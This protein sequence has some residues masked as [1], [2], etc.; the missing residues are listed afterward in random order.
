MKK[1]IIAL[2]LAA[3]LLSA[4]SGPQTHK[5][6][7]DYHVCALVWPSCHDDSLGRVNWE[8]GIGEWE[9]IKKGDPRFEGHY[10]PKLPLW[11]YEMDNDP[12][13]IEKWI[14]TALGHGV[15]TFIYDW[16]WFEHYPFLESALNDGFLKAPSNE[17]MEFFIMWANHDVR[18]CFW[19]YHKWGDDNS[20]LWEGAIDPADFP[21]IV[22]RIINQYF[23]RPN[24]TKIDGCPVFGLFSTDNFFKSFPSR[25]EAVAAMDYMR[26]EVK[27]AGF[28]GM[29]L[30]MFDPFGFDFT[31]HNKDYINS[32]MILKPDSWS[33]YGMGG[34]DCDYLKHGENANMIREEWDA[35]LDIPLF[36]TVS[37]GWDS[38]PR[39]PQN[40]PAE[41]TRFNQTPTVFKS[42]LLDAKNFAD[43]HPDRPKFVILNAWNEWVEGTYLLPDKLWGFGYLE[44]VRDVFGPCIEE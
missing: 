26:E 34:F 13:V 19:N 42:F 7:F 28:P 35:F 23:K 43:R 32:R 37:L 27:K 33:W 15:N 16:Y 9:V 18:R 39:Y 11:G 31:E 3:G 41:V 12:V 40:G 17:K 20:M 8:E 22:E 21:K 30:M 5:N 38:T 36:P 10:Q 44:S 24:Y 29:H 1:T 14:N 4:C 25:E 6:K 2:L